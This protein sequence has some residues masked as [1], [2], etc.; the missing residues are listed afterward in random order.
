MRN[1]QLVSKDEFYLGF[2]C[3]QEIIIS[4]ICRPIPSSYIELMNSLLICSADL[5]LPWGRGAHRQPFIT[6]KQRRPCSTRVMDGT[7]SGVYFICFLSRYYH[8]TMHMFACIG[9]WQDG[10]DG[11]ETGWRRRALQ[12]C[13]LFAFLLIIITCTN[14][15]LYDFFSAAETTTWWALQ[16]ARA[17]QISMVHFLYWPQ[18][19]LAIASTQICL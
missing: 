7:P 14:S 15:F 11:E 19:L 13:S 18:V 5:L 16:P 8:L 17:M 12:V 1:C 9:R 10:L 3:R 2:W 4:F 6:R